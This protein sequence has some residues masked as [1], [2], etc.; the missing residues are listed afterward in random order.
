[1]SN[2][3]DG[4]DARS[5]LEIVAEAIAILRQDASEYGFIAL[6][7]TVPACI[8]VLIPALVGGPVALSLIA[9]LVTLTAL[10]T[11]AAAGAALG[12]A[13]NHLQPDA[14]RAF[15]AAGRRAIRLL[16]PWLPLVIG[17]WAASY[18][19][20]AFAEYLG[21]MPH[22][23]IV[24]VLAAGAAWYA[25]PR[26]MCMPAVFEHDVTS[27]QS[28]AASTALVHASRRRVGLAWA[29]ALA[30]AIATALLAVAGGFDA[31]SGALVAMFFVAAMPFAAAMMSLLFADA[32]D[33]LGVTPAPEP[34]PTQRR[35]MAQRRA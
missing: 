19:A 5:L 34:P 2:R 27:R 15:A 28:A 14:S 25:F 31:V 6:L 1:M 21:P 30:P 11:L 26:S 9:P 4:G 20:A 23:V 29:I 18:A 7:G 8:A 16:L 3:D 22:S 35:K 10:A 12:D 32:V 13:S 33:R 17:L 24:L